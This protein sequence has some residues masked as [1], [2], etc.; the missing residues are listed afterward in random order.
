MYLGTFPT[1]H[2]WD[3]GKE[4]RD[5]ALGPAGAGEVQDPVFLCAHTLV[6]S[7]FLIMGNHTKHRRYFLSYVDTLNIG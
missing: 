5:V 2:Q 7:K 6:A 1:A 4:L 3:E